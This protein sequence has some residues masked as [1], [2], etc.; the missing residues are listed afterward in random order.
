MLKM[1][2]RIDNNSKN[3]QTNETPTKQNK[4]NKQKN[5]ALLQVSRSFL[6]RKQ[7]ESVSTS[8]YV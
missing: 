4:T 6:I 5:P 8:G 1:E 3:K 2:Q 7:V